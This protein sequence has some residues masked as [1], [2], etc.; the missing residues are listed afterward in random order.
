MIALFA[1]EEA[2][3]LWAKANGAEKLCIL[4]IT[5]SSHRRQG[6][7]E[8]CMRFARPEAWQLG[9]CKVEL[10]SGAQRPDAHRIYEKLGVNSDVERS[11]VIKAPVRHFRQKGLL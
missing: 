7:A 10:L 9:C 8:A 6:L 5:A 2:T 3:R 4:V 1:I 11:F